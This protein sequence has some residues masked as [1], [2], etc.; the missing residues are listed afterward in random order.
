MIP[1]I[2]LGSQCFRCGKHQEKGYIWRVI[3]HPDP[4]RRFIQFWCVECIAKA[5]DRTYEMAPDGAEL[6]RQ[7]RIIKI[8]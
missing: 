7:D 8:S 2:D 4:I 5:D 1:D 6:D 3:W